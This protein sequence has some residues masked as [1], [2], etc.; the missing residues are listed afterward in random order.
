[1]TEKAKQIRIETETLETWT[2]KT[3]RH[4]FCRQC[5]AEVSLL[6]LDESVSLAL[7]GT[8]QLL[9]SIDAGRLH[10]DESPAGHLLVCQNSLATHYNLKGN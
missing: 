8:R 9:S 5:D 3:A 6:T 10:G 7:V 2:I 1:M 4:G